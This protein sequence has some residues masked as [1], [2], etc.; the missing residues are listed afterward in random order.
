MLYT[1]IYMHIYTLTG[2][3][4]TENPYWARLMALEDSQYTSTIILAAPK[5]FVVFLWDKGTVINL[6]HLQLADQ[7]FF[8][9]RMQ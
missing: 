6:P 4:A 7:V 8:R 5:C 2:T 3:E 9:L 1:Q